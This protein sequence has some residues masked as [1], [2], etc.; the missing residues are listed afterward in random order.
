MNV[1]VFDIET[2]PDVEAGRKQLSLGED[3]SD[4]AVA[5]AM[6]S[7]AKEAQGTPFVKLHW[8]KIIAVSV[9]FR[10][11][12]GLKIWS[13]G[14]PSYPVDE[15][16]LIRR[17]FA[18]LQKYIPT[19]VSWNGSGFDLP[20]LHYRA[21]RH[22]IESAHYWETGENNPSFKYNNYLN[23]YHTRHEDLMD[24][25]AGFQAKANAKLNDIANLLGLPGKLEMTGEGVF[26]H[27]FQGDIE[28]I[29]HYCEIDVLNTYIIYL[30]FQRIRG[31]LSASEYE[32]EIALIQTTLETSGQAHFQQFLNLW[33]QDSERV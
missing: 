6:M 12:D 16:D 4:K 7:L 18:G 3:I 19:L 33:N 25:L 31:R 22:G 23:R 9:V 27:Y 26:E 1:F 8:Q 21:L 32:R 14:E 15:A 30:R 2:V 13:L 17:F 10:H 28:K 11:Q 29:R 20:V 5:E 24:V